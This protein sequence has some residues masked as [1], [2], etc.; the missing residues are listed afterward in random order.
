VL[1]ASARAL[2]ARLTAAGFAFRYPTVEM[3]LRRALG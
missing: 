1:L 3:A 2:P